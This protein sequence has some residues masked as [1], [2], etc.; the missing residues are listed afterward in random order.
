MRAPLAT[1]VTRAPR[2]R[3]KVR[4]LPRFTSCDLALNERTE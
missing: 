3:F 4:H 1:F 2:F